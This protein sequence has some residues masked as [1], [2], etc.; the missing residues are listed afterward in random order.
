MDLNTLLDDR[1]IMPNKNIVLGELKK[2][3]EKFIT[4][5]FGNCDLFSSLFFGSCIIC[6]EG[7]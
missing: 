2:E 4:V 6:W 1:N 3:K 7:R 5:D